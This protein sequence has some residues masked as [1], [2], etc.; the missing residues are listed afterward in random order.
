[1][2]VELKW[3]KH[4]WVLVLVVFTFAIVSNFSLIWKESKTQTTYLPRN[5]EKE[6]SA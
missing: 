6:H 1:M 4:L 3:S 2:I 5:L